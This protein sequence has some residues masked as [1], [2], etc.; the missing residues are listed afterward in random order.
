MIHQQ[1]KLSVSVRVGLA[2]TSILPKSKTERLI[3]EPIKPN[4]FTCDKNGKHR[5]HTPLKSPKKKTKKK[6]EAAM[7]PAAAKEIIVDSRVAALL[8]E[9]DGIFALKEEEKSDTKSF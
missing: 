6:Q 4:K 7:S 3:P 9:L 5:L 8:S 1:N 2:W